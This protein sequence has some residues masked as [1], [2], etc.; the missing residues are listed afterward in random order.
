MYIKCCVPVKTLCCM[1]GTG[2]RC[3]LSASCICLIACFTSCSGINVGDIWPYNKSPIEVRGILIFMS[4][5]VYRERNFF[6]ECF[7]PIKQ[8]IVHFNDMLL[9]II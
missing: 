7:C 6:E 2:V 8:E 9:L 1:N 3:S 4:A 5:L